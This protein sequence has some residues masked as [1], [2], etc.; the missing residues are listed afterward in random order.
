MNRLTHTHTHTHT[1]TLNHTDPHFNPPSLLPT[2]YHTT[3]R[4]G[5]LT[6]CLQCRAPRV[7]SDSDS[8]SDDGNDD[9]KKR[10]RRREEGAAPRVVPVVSPYAIEWTPM[11]PRLPKVRRCAVCCVV[12][13]CITRLC[14]VCCMLHA[15]VL[16]AC[17]L[18][19]MTFVCSNV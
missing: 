17:M 3:G 4:L 8:E 6:G 15:C 14:A 18:C 5:F 19:C 13:C 10:K 2:S 1:H 16:H 11:A 12:L 9:A 7:D